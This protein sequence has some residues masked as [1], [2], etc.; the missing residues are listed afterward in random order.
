MEKIRRAAEFVKNRFNAIPSLAL[1][2]G[3]G[4]GKFPDTV[5]IID[6]IPYNAI[7]GH[8]ISTVPGHEGK[9]LLAAHKNNGKQFLIMQGRVH[10]YEGYSMY[11]VVFP[12]RM[13][14][15][16]G[17]CRLLVTNA[18]GGVDPTFDAGDLMIIDDHLNLMGTSPLI[19]RNFDRLGPRFSDMS[20]PY[21]ARIRS[22]IKQVADKEHIPIR[23]GVY[24]ALTGPSFETPAEIRMLGVL[25]AHAVGMSTVPEVIVAKHAEMEV[26]GVSFISNKGSGLSDTPLSHEEVGEKAKEI[27]P[28]FATLMNGVVAELLDGE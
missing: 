11:D 26:G 17:V 20:E 9:L 15:T 24:A 25:G 23:S 27:E 28:V 22:I 8:P 19:G 21:S 12:I 7:P 1:I 16:L 14:A 5:D 2:L 10:F 13:F 6:E 4:L 3:S 18:A